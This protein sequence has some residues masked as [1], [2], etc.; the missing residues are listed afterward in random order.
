MKRKEK[1]AWA[2]GIMALVKILIAFALISGLI[3]GLMGGQ[4]EMAIRAVALSAAL[5]L[6]AKIG[7]ILWVLGKIGP[8]SEDR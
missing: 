8:K 1:E 4:I 5:F 2:R 6:V 7:T 3:K